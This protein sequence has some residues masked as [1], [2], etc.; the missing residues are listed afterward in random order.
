MAVLVTRRVTDQRNAS[1]STDGEGMSGV[2]LSKNL[3]AGA[4]FVSA[5][6]RALA[7]CSA[8]AMNKSFSSAKLAMPRASTSAINEE[9]I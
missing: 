2:K 5:W 3:L 8:Q 9:R 6:A 7:T 4:C 1:A